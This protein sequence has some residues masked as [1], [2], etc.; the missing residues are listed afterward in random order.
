MKIGYVNASRQAVRDEQHRAL[1]AAGC[2]RV[3]LDAGDLGLRSRPA[4][5][6]IIQALRRNDEVLVVHP[7]CIA[8][9]VE[10]IAEIARIV[11]SRGGELVAVGHAGNLRVG[12]LGE[13][14]AAAE[15]EAAIRALEAG[16]PPE[17]P[18][19]KRGRPP[20]VKN[21]PKVPVRPNPDA[22]APSQWDAAIARI[23]SRIEAAD[24]ESG[25]TGAAIALRRQLGLSPVPLNG[26]AERASKPR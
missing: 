7:I 24:L 25:V 9:D 5:H 6:G 23:A 20:G 4:L 21:K 10:I 26:A 17:P 12:V 18:K 19:G 22:A 15:V 11:R 3:E 8:S 16:R 2:D 1:T 14:G 13:H